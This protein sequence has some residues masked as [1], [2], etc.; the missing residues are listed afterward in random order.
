[1]IQAGFSFYGRNIQAPGSC[2]LKVCS[3]LWRKGGCI[4]LN[5]SGCQSL[6]TADSVHSSIAFAGS[7]RAVSQIR[8]VSPRVRISDQYPSM[9]RSFRIFRQLK[10]FFEPYRMTS[11]ELKQRRSSCH[12]I[13][14]SKRRKIL[15]VLKHFWGIF[16]FRLGF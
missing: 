3:S 12:H 10:Q 1:M 16:D 4:H 2:P 11:M 5:T 14:P 15:K 8:R 9:D 13:V 7:C 6:L